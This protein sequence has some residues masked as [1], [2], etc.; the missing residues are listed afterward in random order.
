MQRRVGRLPDSLKFR[1]FVRNQRAWR[2]SG[3]L[4]SAPVDLQL[5]GGRVSREAAGGNAPEQCRLRK[6]EN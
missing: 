6:P 3:Q 2:L 5:A 1:F 4:V